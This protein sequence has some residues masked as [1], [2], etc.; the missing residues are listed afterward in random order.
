MTARRREDTGLFALVTGRLAVTGVLVAVAV[1]LILLPVRGAARGTDPM[2]TPASP[3]APPAGIPLAEVATRAA[4]LP[5][6]LR[7]LTDPLASS[8]ELETIRRSLPELRQRFD[9]ELATLEAL[10]K[11]QP[12]L[13][14]IQAQQQLWQRRQ[15]EASRWLSMLTLRATHLQEALGRL[16]EIE[17]T[18]RRTLHAA[19]EAG[20]A[21]S[22][23]AQIDEA[24]AAIDAARLSL[25]A[26]RT[27]VLD[28]QG[29]VVQEVTRL[30]SAVARLLQAQQR[31]VAGILT[32]D[33]PPLWDPQ[34]WTAARDTLGGH[35]RDVAAARWNDLVLYLGDLRRGALPH[36]VIFATLAVVFC[37]ARRRI[38][39]RR[40]D[41]DESTGLAVFERPYAMA[42][43]VPAL[44]AS[45][46]ISAAPP[47]LR[48]LFAMRAA[49]VAIRL[50]GPVTGRRLMPAIY[51]VAALFALDS[52]RQAVG[53]APV[54]DQTILAV[55]TLAGVVAVG[56]SLT[57]G[58]LRRR[59]MEEAETDQLHLL[60]L[61]AGT[62]LLLFAVGLAAAV[63]GYMP[64]ARL[65]TSGLLASG[66]LALTLKGA[67]RA[68]SG[69][70][71][72]TLLVWPLRL[73]RMVHDHRHLLA[74]RA[75]GL[76]GLLAI[77]AWTVRSLDHVGL[78]EPVVAFA[79][80]LLTAELGRGSITFSVGDVLEFV[81]TV[82]LAY[83]VSA[84]IRFVLQ[85][86]VYPRT[87][88]TRGL[89]YAVSS[90]LNY[91]VLTLGFL[92]ALGAL[93]L[94]LTKLTI[95]AGAFGVGLGFGLQSVVNNFV[96]GLLL[97]FERPIH[98]GDVIEIDD[99]LGEVTRIGIRA[100]TVRTVQGAEMIVPNAQLVAERV[101][102]WTLSDRRRR[103]EIAVSVAYASPPEK[104]VA[105]L[106]AVAQ[107]HPHVLKDPAPQALFIAFGDS[108]I[109]FELR[110][111]TSQF[112]GWATIRSELAI[113][114]YAALQ[115]AGMTIPFPQ[116]EV[117]L[118]PS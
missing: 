107:G 87:R 43:I 85:E 71:G 68:A 80:A 20:A 75:Q 19:A 102:N 37:A 22:L 114:V 18:W 17:T 56:W 73:L 98:V 61:A 42:L 74:R 11:S 57:S 13:A 72:F 62:I 36:A 89:S 54:L 109:D 48:S 3:A 46:P 117:R 51:T 35:F 31:A 24:L 41:G 103:I 38:H 67:I 95:L 111:W 96:S 78:F 45:A 94:D 34:A 91:I 93:G 52:L 63:A 33:S 118:V 82:W 50:T 40:L 97:L 27:A 79:G 58:P 108:A 101:T 66:A 59:S 16:A 112:E 106:R 69:V 23:L 25:E 81:L 53:G 99:L 44:V 70:V 65:L 113:A 60:R 86:D 110:A 77:V 47:S 5:D 8:A 4:Q 2:T 39:Q 6:V 10:L 14:M 115:G 104:V 83:L 29:V 28:L 90:L 7:T 84:F 116:R 92:L 9:L 105:V 32:R 21:H 1:V 15:V 64:V 49:A 88:L 100:S 76:L 12:T 30:G 55:E 26:Q